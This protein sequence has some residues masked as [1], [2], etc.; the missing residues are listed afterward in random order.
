MVVGDLNAD[1]NDGDGANGTIVDL[2]SH[3]RVGQGDAP[4]SEGAVEQSVLQGGINAWHVGDPASDT[5][6]WS[7]NA[8]GNV[9][10]DYVLPS[11]D[12]EVDRSGVFWP[13]EDEVGFEWVGRSPFPV[14]DHRLVWVTMW[15]PAP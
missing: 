11:A 8:V 1:P 2:L 6:D 9:R 10:V 3:A 15:V 12:L 7:D 13:K 14:S 5:A 4:G